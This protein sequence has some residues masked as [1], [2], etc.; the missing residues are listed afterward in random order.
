MDRDRRYHRLKSPLIFRLQ[1]GLLKSQRTYLTRPFRS[2]M[3]LRPSLAISS[4][5]SWHMAV[6]LEKYFRRNWANASYPAPTSKI[7]IEAS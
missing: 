7:V 3:R 6:A 5:P 1:P 2:F 4:D